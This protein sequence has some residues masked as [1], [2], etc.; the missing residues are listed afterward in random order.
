[1]DIHTVEPLVPKPS[2]VK[3]EIA[4]GELRRYKSL[5]TDQIS[6]ELIKAGSETSCSDIHKCIQST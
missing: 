2:L 6:A 4:T 1:M 5:G 3:V